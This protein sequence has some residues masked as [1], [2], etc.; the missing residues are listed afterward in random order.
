MFVQSDSRAPKAFN[1]MAKNPA[2]KKIADLKSKTV[3]GQKGSALNHLLFV[4]LKKEGLTPADIKY[5]NM[6][7]PRLWTHRYRAASMQLLLQ[8]RRLSQMR[9]QVHGWYPMAMV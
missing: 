3:A 1:V 2:I 9:W 5:V 4:A 6:A 8:G 7:G